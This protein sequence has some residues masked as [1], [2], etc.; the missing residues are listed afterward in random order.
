M[1]KFVFM[2]AEQDPSMATAF[3][4]WVSALG[5]YTSRDILPAKA[6]DWTIPVSQGETK[7]QTTSFHVKE[8][9]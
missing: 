2:I 8:Y 3:G 4:G 7:M 5:W 1:F 6:S 9:G